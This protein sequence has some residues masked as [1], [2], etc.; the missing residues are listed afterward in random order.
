MKACCTY[1]RNDPRPKSEVVHEAKFSS[2]ISYSTDVWLAG[3]DKH[4]TSKLVMVSV[5]SSIPTGGNFVID[6]WK[7]WAI[8]LNFR[9][10]LLRSF[11]TTF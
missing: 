8:T 4:Q 10:D 2:K 9:I 3:M 7:Y 6:E 1:S 11:S 5:L